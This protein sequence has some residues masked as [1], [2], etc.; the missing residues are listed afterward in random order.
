MVRESDR[1]EAVGPVVEGEER[2]REEVVAEVRING[3]KGRT[4]RRMM[5]RRSKGSLRV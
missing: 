2:T 3:T 5:K 4:D 1:S